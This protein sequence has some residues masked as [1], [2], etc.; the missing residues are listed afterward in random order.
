MKKLILCVA[1]LLI[2][3]FIS[4]C[5]FFQPKKDRQVLLIERQL[6]QTNKKIDKIYDKLNKMLDMLNRHEKSIEDLE[7]S[8]QRR[9]PK[10]YVRKSY[11]PRPSRKTKTVFHYR[12]KAHPGAKKIYEHAISAHNHKQYALSKK[13]FQS[14]ISSYPDD[15]LAEKAK[16]WIMYIEKTY[17]SSQ[18]K[19][20]YRRTYSSGTVRRTGKYASS[21]AGKSGH[22]YKKRAS[23]Y[24]P[25]SKSSLYTQKKIIDRNDL[26][27]RVYNKGVDAYRQE[28]YRTSISLFQSIVKKY[29]RHHLAFDSL[30]WIGESHYALHNYYDAIISFRKVVSKNPKGKTVPESL[31]KAGYAYIALDDT[32]NARRY[33]KKVAAE[34]AST[35]QGK[36]AREKLIELDNQPSNLPK[37][38][39]KRRTSLQ[40]YLNR[41][42]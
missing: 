42:L 40:V 41:D 18:S 7:L 6:S 16:Y 15:D 25:E 27:T 17:G 24:K 37:D 9:A 11:T 39:Q 13:L 5:S 21:A 26:V 23:L 33:L 22:S 31:L 32:I 28:D 10:S 4:S 29:P 36:E 2:P 34:F 3:L 19:K 12:A 14:V 35:P 20:T 38:R 8:L 30:Y 1:F